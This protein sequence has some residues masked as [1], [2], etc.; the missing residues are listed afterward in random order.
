M[1]YRDGVTGT[2]CTVFKGG[3]SLSRV[4]GLI[5][6]F[7]EDVDLLVLFPTEGD[8][9]GES[10][11]DGLLKRI[12]AEV[13]EHLDAVRVRIE[14]LDSA[15]GI[16]RKVKYHYPLSGTVDSVLAEGVILEMGSRGGPEPMERYPLRSIAAEYAISELGESEDQ[17]EEFA[18]FD[19]NVLGAE[20]TL[21][22][23]LSAVHSITSTLGAKQPPDGWGRHFHDIHRLL[24][25]ADIRA[26][27]V[28]M[29]PDE[30]IRLVGDI[31]ERTD[32]GFGNCVRRPAD[33][34]ASSPA[35]DLDASVAAQVRAAYRD[36][37]GLMY[38]SVVP[39]EECI[40][41]VHSWAQLL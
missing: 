10:A 37:G 2:A 4:Y 15:R 27:L 8:G 31:E 16:K 34:Y 40:A 18:S 5:D 14:R 23:K 7:S 32:A 21:L 17:W 28:A 6:R 13:H 36:V 3:T 41:T 35:F 19:V 11:R 22:E 29:G 24:Q 25:S 1:T 39:F 9:P 12:A 20:R 33:G 38:D 30:V 26:K